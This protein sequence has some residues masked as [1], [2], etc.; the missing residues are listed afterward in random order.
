METHSKEFWIKA[1]NDWKASGLSQSMFCRE[2][3]LSLKRFYYFLAKERKKSSRFSRVE[4]ETPAESE[5]QSGFVITFPNGA[6]LEI[7]A[8]TMAD[9]KELLS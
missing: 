4:F 5:D 6:K 8:L 3:G 2:R 9:L 7:G 1:I